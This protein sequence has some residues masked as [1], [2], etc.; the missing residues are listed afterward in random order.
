MKHEE[1]QVMTSLLPGD[2]RT[3]YILSLTDIPQRDI[4]HAGAKAATLGEM[5]RAGFP[6]PNGF[7]LT[8]DAFD[9]FLM[10][11]TLG[12]AISPEAVIAATLPTD[13]AEAL[14]AA[15]NAL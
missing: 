9:R 14:L 6:V 12:P 1:V 5:A 13:V 8:T 11:N 15:A 10:A 7:V 2:A 4:E 3:N